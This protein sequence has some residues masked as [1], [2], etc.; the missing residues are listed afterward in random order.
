[1]C[2]K[3]K[4][5]DS[6]ND[7]TYPSPNKAIPQNNIKLKNNI[8]SKM[9]QENKSRK[10]CNKNMSSMLSMCLMTPPMFLVIISP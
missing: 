9:M 5:S 1:M 3:R 10:Y 4:L 8:D 7:N 2:K 6:V